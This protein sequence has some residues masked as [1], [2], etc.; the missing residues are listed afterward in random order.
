[1]T[2][3]IIAMTSGME[4]H[5]P[6]VAQADATCNTEGS[7]PAPPP[8]PSPPPLSPPLVGTQLSPPSSPFCG[9]RDCGAPCMDTLKGVLGGAGGGGGEMFTGGT[10]A[11]GM[12]GR[13]DQGGG[14]RLPWH[15][16]AAVGAGDA[17]AVNAASMLNSGVS[18]FHLSM[19]PVVKDE[20][21]GVRI[22]REVETTKASSWTPGFGVDDEACPREGIGEPDDGR[23]G[24]ADLV[25]TE[26]D[27][28]EA[29][30]VLLEGTSPGRVSGGGGVGVRADSWNTGVVDDA[31]RSVSPE[32]VLPS[33][34]DGA[35]IPPP[36]NDP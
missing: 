24:P 30:Y 9:I 23:A 29:A 15:S 25:V 31:S 20:Q 14:D 26:A 34:A 13:L 8:P 7:A 21:A 6:F 10:L 2:R 12:L 28:L 17:P 22:G 3:N 33:S 16:T 32:F 19:P 36:L 11:G 35:G 1:M 4:Q 5:S 18:S 27:M